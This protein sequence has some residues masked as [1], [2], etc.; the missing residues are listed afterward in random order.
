M[1]TGTRNFLAGTT[2]LWDDFWEMISADNKRIAKNTL[3]LYCRMA[4]T[5]SLG[6]F[7]TRVLLEALG[8]V[9]YG[10]VNVIGGIVAMFS[11]LSGMM[12]SACSRFYN[13]EI[14][15]K[16]FVRLRQ[17]FNLVQLIY[18][19]L[20]LLLF[21]LAETVGVWFLENRIVVPPDRV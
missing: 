19:F 2:N 9:D 7:T 13:F 8:V 15:R 14:G 10:L 6:I 11:F 18:V 17:T 4:V 5:M 16:D 20:V 3:M 1:R 12:S 21:V